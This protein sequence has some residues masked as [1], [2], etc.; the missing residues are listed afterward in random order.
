MGK[1]HIDTINLSDHFPNYAQSER[2]SPPGTW[3]PRFCHPL[4]IM[5]ISDLH[6]HRW[7]ASW[8]AM[9]REIGAIQCDL[10]L[11]TGDLTHSHR[12]HERK[13]DLVGRFLE[14]IAPRI[15]TYAVLGNHDSSELP[16]SCDFQGLRI[17]NNERV[18]V[19]IGQ[20]KLLHL[21][22]LNQCH[23]SPRTLRCLDGGPGNPPVDI[24]L[25]HYPST[26][27]KLP[28]GRVRL[29]LSGHTHG[30]Q[31]RFPLV[32]CLW[33]NDSVPLAMSRGW[34][35]VGQTYLHVSAG[36]GV[37]PICSVRINCPPQA[38]LLRLPAYPADINRDCS[39]RRAE[40][41]QSSPVHQRETA[42]V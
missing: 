27:Y 23:R 36:L 24:L 4:S 6:L 30:G 11:I 31:I 10:V 7:S 25:A 21:A 1:V 35:R 20:G 16:G 39:T 5:H 37:S 28:A 29:Q 12:N 19:E 18:T 22:G 8:E 13:G 41:P 40:N 34:H 32:G 38:T 42:G 2:D 26:I 14:H 33:N 15:G 3:F 9:S 17:L